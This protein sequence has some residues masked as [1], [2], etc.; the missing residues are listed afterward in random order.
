ME[1]IQSISLGNG[2]TL[3]L[4]LYL[5]LLGIGTPMF[6]KA[7][8]G[9]FWVTFIAI[10]LLLGG[11]A[12]LMM[13]AGAPTNPAE[14][15]RFAETLEAARTVALGIV[16]SADLADAPSDARLTERVQR[17]LDMLGLDHEAAG[18]HLVV[19][20]TCGLAGA[21]PAWAAISSIS[22]STSAAS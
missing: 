4:G 17:W 1:I 20:P 16:P 11:S 7:L 19:T 13:M 12:N 5:F 21:T 9:K 2:I 18:E 10:I 8:R 15:A 6:P 3:A 22:R 14:L